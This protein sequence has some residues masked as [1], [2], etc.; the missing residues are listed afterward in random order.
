MILQIINEQQYSVG[1]KDLF[2]IFQNFLQI[3]GIKQRGQINLIFVDHHTIRKLNLLYRNKDDSTDV[4]SFPYGDDH[5]APQNIKH[6]YGEI[7]IN[8]YKAV[9]Q[10]KKYQN[11]SEE[12]VW[13]LLV[14][15]LLHI[16]GFRHNNLK[17]KF[18]MDNLTKKIL[19]GL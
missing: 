19:N 15:G 1:E 18:I 10:A 4:L 17:Q 11:T 16:W 7:F 12:E 2:L 5:F 9:E 13:F 3:L 14:H 8:Y 6:I